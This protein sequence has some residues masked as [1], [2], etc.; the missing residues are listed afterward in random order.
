MNPGAIKVSDVRK[1][2]RGVGIEEELDMEEAI[3]HASMVAQ[4]P[5]GEAAAA[6]ERRKSAASKGK[7]ARLE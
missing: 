4:A 1:R 2:E 3:L 7:R 5:E 6:E